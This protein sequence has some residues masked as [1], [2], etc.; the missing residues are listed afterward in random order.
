MKEVRDYYDQFDSCRE[1]DIPLCAESC[2]F[3]L[4]IL[5]LTELITAGRFSAA[6]KSYRD[7]VVFP[8]IVSEI[9]PGYCRDACIRRDLDEALNLPLLEKSLVALTS[10]RQPNAYNLPRR[11]EKIAVI[12]AGIS[13]MTFALK[14][15]SRKYDVTVFEREAQIGGHLKNLMDEDVYIKEF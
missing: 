9:C 4:D 8:G 6:Y 7:C 12:G 10:R 11:G 2:P 14:M 13:G 15:A 5:T 1:H 3:C